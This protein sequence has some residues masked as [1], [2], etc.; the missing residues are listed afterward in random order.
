MAAKELSKRVE[1]GAF[2]QLILLHNLYSQ[3][4]SESILFQGGTALRWV[5]GGLRASEDLDF[6]SPLPQN[7]LL[8]IINR[9]FKGA[10]L[11]TAPQF[12]TG[13]FE[14]KP[15]QSPEG[16]L[17]TFAIYRPDNQRERIVVRVEVE[18]L[19]N[20]TLPNYRKV[21]FMDCPSI[22]SLMRDGSLTL[23]YSSSIISVESPEEILGGKIRALFERSYLKGRDLYDLWFLHNMLETRI[24]LSQLQNK[25]ESYFR[26]FHP[27]RKA[28]FFLTK[29]NHR[30]LQKVLQT[31][32][33][34]F[35]PSPIY[36][37]LEAS[38]FEAILQ[39]LEDILNPLSEEG[40]EEVIALYG[41]TVNH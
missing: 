40:L 33:R 14:E 7:R 18:R 27:A 4:G 19:T 36:K 29:E 22:F 2:L 37:E 3:S 35:L 32:L 16:C 20:G 15:V 28:I 10:S 1:Q 6:V 41:E 8:K 21:P 23:S 39:A 17:R 13:K 25:F 31:D 30:I 12:G 34:P 5:Y 26:P 24:T 11:L 38:G 9:A